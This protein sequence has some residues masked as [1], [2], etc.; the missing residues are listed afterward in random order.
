M[1]YRMT[2]MPPRTPPGMAATT[3]PN[4][5]QRT[6]EEGEAG[7]GPV[8]GGGV[9]AGGRHDAD[10]LGVRGVG[11]A[12]D[13]GGE[14]R[15]GTVGRDGGAQLVVQVVAGHLADRLDVPGVLR[16]EGDDHGQRHQDRRPLEARGVEGGQPD[17][18]GLP[19]GGQVQAPVVDRLGTAG[20]AVDL[21]ED[22]VEDPGE[23]V[24]EDQAEEDRDAGEEAA[25][26]DH[27]QAGEEHHQQRRPLVLRPVGGGRDRGEVEADQHD[28]GT[29]DHRRHR[30]VD[31][32]RAEL[33]HH[34]A[35]EEEDRRHDQHGAGDG[36]A[37]AAARPDRRRHPD[38]RQG[39]AQI[40]G[41]LPAG[42][43]QEDHGG[44]TRHHDREVGVEPHQDGCHERGAEHGHDVL[45]A[46]ARRPG[47]A[48][49]LVGAY[50]GPRC[51]CPS[52]AVQGPA[53]AEAHG[54]SLLIA[55]SPLRWPKP[56]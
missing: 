52:V 3:A 36:G 18:V 35:G 4:F 19:D 12:A 13:R 8:G 44:D 2:V 50:H 15:G 21:A 43:Q 11:R 14:H 54:R 7:G 22:E 40:A 26:A 17:P 5:G 30:R 39:A 51:G 34:E 45:G 31:D 33:A 20:R 9:D 48:Q 55:R 24:A 49:P 6:E 1:P 29:G 27:G 47:P 25:Q 10:V 56:D 42:R 37:V 46:E 16:D 32:P 53:H 41:H 38:E 28:D 23:Q